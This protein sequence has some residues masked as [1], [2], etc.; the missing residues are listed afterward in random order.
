MSDHR[1]LKGLAE[2]LDASIDELTREYR[3][4]EDKWDSLAVVCAV[5]LIDESYDVTIDGETLRQCSTVGEL[6]EAIAQKQQDKCAA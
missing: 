2:E 4:T 3:L 1:F 6:L 5:G